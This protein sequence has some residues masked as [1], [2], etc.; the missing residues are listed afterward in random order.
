MTNAGHAIVTEAY[1]LLGVMRPG[2]TAAL[3]WRDR[4]VFHMTSL[5]EEFPGLSDSQMAH[6]LAQRLTFQPKRGF[7]ARLR[8]ALRGSV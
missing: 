6:K 4:A 5:A 7:F 2:E 8:W 3:V 1:I